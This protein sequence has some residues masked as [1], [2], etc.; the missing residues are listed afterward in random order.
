MLIWTPA[1]SHSA[2]YCGLVK[3]LPWSWFQM[4]GVSPP[5][6]R[7]GRRLPPVL[8]HGF[9]AFGVVALVGDEAG[10][11]FMVDPVTGGAP[12]TANHEDLA[13]P[14][15]RPPGPRSAPD[16]HQGAGAHRTPTHGRAPHIKGSGAP[17]LGSK[18]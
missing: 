14:R 1:A 6:A 11:Q 17:G 16:G 5:R 9:P 10:G 7:A 4:T 13:V 2:G 8:H 15:R 18:A 3:W 12:Q